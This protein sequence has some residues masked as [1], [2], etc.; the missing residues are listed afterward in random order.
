[1]TNSMSFSTSRRGVTAGH[2]SSGLGTGRITN[3]FVGRVRGHRAGYRLAVQRRV[4]RGDRR[5]GS[6][7]Q[8][9]GSMRPA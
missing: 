1:M 2:P 9:F 5:E 7:R 8:A 3:H 6:D 4:D